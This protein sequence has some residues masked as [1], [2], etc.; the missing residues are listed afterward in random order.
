ML[1]SGLDRSLLREK[2]KKEIR[3]MG[4]AIPEVIIQARRWEQVFANDMDADF[5]IGGVTSGFE[6]SYKPIECQFY[7]VPNYVEDEHAHKVDAALADEFAKGRVVEVPKEFLRGC[8]AL[9]VVDKDHS[10]MA[11][12]R[13]VHDLSRPEGCSTNDTTTVQKR[14]FATV[15]DAADLIRPGYFMA[16][17]DLSS[18]YRSIPMPARYYRMFGMKWRK[19]YYADLRLAF[20]FRPAPEIFDRISTALV[21]YVRANICPSFLGYIDDFF[22]CAATKEEAL[23]AYYAVVRFFQSL[24]LVV[25]EKPEKSVLPCH[26]LTFL[27]I[28][29]TTVFENGLSCA[30]RLSTDRVQKVA[31]KCR[32]F[33]REN[34]IGEK[35]LSSFLGTLSFCSQVLDGAKLY[36]KSSFS[37]LS[38]C[39]KKPRTIPREVKLDIRWWLTLLEANNGR[40]VAVGHRKILPVSRA[41]MDASTTFGMGG[42][43]DGRFFSTPWEEIKHIK[44]P[45]FPHMKEGQMHINYLELFTVFWFLQKFGRYIS[46]YTLPFM[47]DN[48][49]T[50]YVLKNMT[51]SARFIPL[52]KQIQKLIIRY[53]I[54]L[55]PIRVKSKDN[56]LADMLS[57]G[58]M[59]GFLRAR[60]EWKAKVGEIKDVDDCRVEETFFA[61]YDLS[62]K[63]GP[64]VVDACCDDLGI[65]SFCRRF[66]SPSNSC[67]KHD[68]A[69][70]R[71]FC[72]PPFSLLEEILRHAIK[73][74]RRSPL[75][76]SA[77]FILPVWPQMEYW[78]IMESNPDILVIVE[79]IEKGTSMFTVPSRAIGVYERFSLGPT[80]WPVVVVWMHGGAC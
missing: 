11:K 55:L 16:K 30:C 20:G 63:F 15:M 73:C 7:E 60:E 29:L 17:I 18:A 3:G 27:G 42:F 35:R 76:T 74:K 62:S 53:D 34:T 26:T 57:R 72:N 64:F 40:H 4:G 13:L 37:L 36:L 54:K 48:T 21:R 59:A 78:N 41:A 19:K 12:V 50:E 2:F 33:L 9:G 43:L 39:K 77:L 25:N 79:R 38:V 61:K 51:G 47:E 46:G 10:G 66:W 22:L 65:N 1:V 28:E 5:L 75:G 56:L 23:E 52:L 32:D 31:A 69:G 45:V 80:R 71:V 44:N 67:L 6:F 8:S 49:V 14:K 24:G 70:E 58:D 68:W